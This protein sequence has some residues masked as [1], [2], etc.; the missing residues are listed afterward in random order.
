[1]SKEEIIVTT[2]KLSIV[3]KIMAALNLGDN[4]K[5]DS[6]FGRAVK[7]LKRE[8]TQYKSNLSTELV[9]RNIQ[10]E[11]LEASL[12]D[13]TGDLEAAYLQIDVKELNNNAAQDAYREQYFDRIE[14][15]ESK[16]T[17]LTNDLKDLNTEI[18]DLTKTYDEKIQVRLD[19]IERISK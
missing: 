15:A 7:Q 8:I 14:S 1:M 13:A 6:F 16:I 4:G 5:L 11:D 12:E 17:S 2:S 10:K 18:K 3:N 9:A 19:R